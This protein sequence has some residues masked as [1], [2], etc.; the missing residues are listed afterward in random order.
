MNEG[1]NGHPRLEVDFKPPITIVITMDQLTSE[2]KVQGPLENKVIFLGMIEMAK[3]ACLNL[4]DMKREPAGTQLSSVPPG[5]VPFLT[6][7]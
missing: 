3:H 2:I 5:L 6:K 7:K 4:K 1:N